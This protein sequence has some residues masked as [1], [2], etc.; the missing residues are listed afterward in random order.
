M[1]VK[2]DPPQATPAARDRPSWVQRTLCKE[3]FAAPPPAPPAGDPAPDAPAANPEGV[4]A[5]LAIA[6]DAVEDERERGRALDTKCASLAGFTGLILSITAALTPAL[7]DHKLGTVGKPLAETT[8]GLAILFLLAAVLLAIEGVLMP[9]KY[10]SMGTAQVANFS[11]PNIQAQEA[12]WVHRS[13]LGALSAILAQDR[14][15]NNCKA[16]LTKWVGRCLAIGFIAVSVD[17]VIIAIRQFG[18]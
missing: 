18:L 11:L 9:Q 17:A 4:A 10:R 12:V 13:M 3:C 15:V 14:P 1:S 2:P 5:L 16:K 7:V 6:T 8:F